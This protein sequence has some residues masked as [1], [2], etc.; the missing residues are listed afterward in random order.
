MLVLSL[1]HKNARCIQQQLLLGRVAASSARVL[2]GWREMFPELCQSPKAQLGKC[3]QSHMG[4][5]RGK[6]DRPGWSQRC[7]GGYR[8]ETRAAQ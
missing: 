4:G 5:G 3:P 7:S 2:P 6:G 8:D 1:F